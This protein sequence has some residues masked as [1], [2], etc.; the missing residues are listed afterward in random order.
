MCNPRR[1]THIIRRRAQLFLERSDVGF[2][3]S[4]LI[5]VLRFVF[6]KF[7]QVFLLLLEHHV[8]CVQLCVFDFFTLQMLK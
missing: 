2:G 8:Q 3:S 6:A 1:Y 5:A 4:D 7:L